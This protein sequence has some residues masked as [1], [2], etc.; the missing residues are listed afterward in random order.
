MEV[1]ISWQS[2]DHVKHIIVIEKHKERHS[3]IYTIKCMFIPMHGLP[4]LTFQQHNTYGI[5]NEHVNACSC[6]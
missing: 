5:M 2:Q 4:S 1:S 6:H 3:T